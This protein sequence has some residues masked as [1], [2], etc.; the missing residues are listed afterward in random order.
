[1]IM[2]HLVKRIKGV[3]VQQ[4]SKKSDIV[5][6][7]KDPIRYP[8]VQCGYEGVAQVMI[9]TQMNNMMNSLTEEML[10]LIK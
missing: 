4:M 6:H 8:K 7:V 9:A 2:N 3:E 5:C 1:M 10:K